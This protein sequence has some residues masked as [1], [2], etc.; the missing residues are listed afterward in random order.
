MKLRKFTLILA[1]FL[2]AGTLFTFG[3]GVGINITGA[4]AN[5]KSMLDVEATGKGM[6]I[7]RM[8][9]VNK[10]TGLTSSE[11]GMIIYSTDGD[12][13]NGPGFY[14]YDGSVWTNLMTTSSFS[15]GSFIENQSATAQTGRF[16][17]DGNGI[18]DGGNVGV[19]SI[20][21]GAKVDVYQALSGSTS[22]SSKALN[23]I[24]NS[25]YNTTGG[26][27]SSYS[28]YFSNSSSRSSGGNNLINVGLFATAINGQLNYAAI[29]DQGN[30]GIGSTSPSDK[31][32][33][34][35]NVKISG[36]SSP[37][38]TTSIT[39]ASLL[40]A[41]STG[42]L[43]STLG[44]ANQVLKMNSGGTAIEWGAPVS[45]SLSIPA[46]T[47]DILYYNGTSWVVLNT[48]GT[49]AGGAG[50]RYALTLP[51]AG[52]GTPSWQATDAFS[53]S[54]DGMGNCVASTNINLNSFNL[55]GT[56]NINISGRITSN[57]IQETSDARFKKNV[58]SISNVLSKVLSV[59]GVS[60]NWKKEE[61]PHKSF[62]TK[63]E[64]G[65][66]AQDLEQIF[67]ELVETDSDGYKSVQYS[68]MVPVLLE[69][70]KEQQKLIN[71]LQG[72]VSNLSQAVYGKDL[73]KPLEN[74]SAELKK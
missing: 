50:V 28:G 29:F 63:T 52:T 24:Q 60:Y 12:G 45:S 64:L 27:I 43:R 32:D 61:F 72:T 20:T 26:I 62:G 36:L 54:G 73:M 13:T 31:L 71:Q 58:K 47:G 22:S 51:N 14:F 15:A 11:A 34:V 38:A 9:W 39:N 23:S 18:F 69:A 70:I 65:F 49:S 33:V 8:T 4:P 40:M 44:T 19:G 3:Q 55:T 2:G 6:L 74:S 57:G 1:A 17:I 46:T 16:R 25:S 10:P 21:P 5:S 56:G 7:P 53:V 67:P 68:H 66:I 59:Q 35:G 42:E 37:V 48:P 30:V 41:S